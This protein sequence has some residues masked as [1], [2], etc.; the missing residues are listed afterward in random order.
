MCFPH[1]GRRGEEAAGSR[2]K[3]TSN[4]IVQVDF[5]PKLKD[6]PGRSSPQTE[7]GLFELGI[8]W[9]S[10]H[11]CK[12]LVLL[13]MTIPHKKNFG[14]KVHGKL[15]W[16]DKWKDPPY[17]LWSQCWWQ[18]WKD[19]EPKV[20]HVVVAGQ[21]PLLHYTTL[22]LFCLKVSLEGEKGKVP[23]LSKT[24]H[25]RSAAVSVKKPWPRVFS[26]VV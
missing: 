9:K 5:H 21:D 22:C 26:A 1:S 19:W 13:L 16:N 15:H 18:K 8:F 7:N 11:K 2:R 24:S 17:L 25:C 10:L 23:A 6:C 4:R 3:S 20:V 12:F 14:T